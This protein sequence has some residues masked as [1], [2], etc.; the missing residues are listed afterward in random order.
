MLSPAAYA[1]RLAKVAVD[2][3][4]RLPGRVCER[5]DLVMVFRCSR[6]AMLGALGIGV[7]LG[8][9]E[10]LGTARAGGIG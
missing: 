1:P 5:R 6:R 3:V 7:C 8:R 10:Q 9:V 4:P 2:R